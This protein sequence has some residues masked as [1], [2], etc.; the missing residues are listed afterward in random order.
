MTK[1]KETN[2]KQ[3]LASAFREMRKQGVIARLSV[4][5]CCRTCI[6]H[7]MSEEWADKPVIW[8]YSGQGNQLKYDLDDNVASHNAIFLNHNSEK[9]PEKI[10]ECVEIL[11]RNGLVTQWSG[12]ETSCV[13]V[14]FQ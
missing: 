12:D 9:F 3:K 11:K 14:M 2:D 4:G 13:G 1:T 8:F 5:G 6:W 10:A 7:E